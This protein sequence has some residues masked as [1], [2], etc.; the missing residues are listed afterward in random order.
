MD[1][2]GAAEVIS[3]RKILR[4]CVLLVATLGYLHGWAQT[5]PT[6]AAKQLFEQERWSDLAQLL[7]QS[8][9]NNADLDYYYGVALAHLERWAEAGKALSDGQR[10]APNDKRF[11][12]E[13]AGVAF[14]QKKYGEAR[15][16]LHRALRLDAKDEY[17]NEFLATV[18]FLEGNLEAALKYWNR[19][20]KPQVTEVRSEPA[21]KVRPALL[22]HAFAFAPAST[23]TLEELLASN[24]RLRGLEIFST[25]KL[26]LEARPDGKFDAILRAQELNGFGNSKLQALVRIFSGALFEEI[27]PEYYNLHGS[28]TNIISLARFDTDKRRAVAAINGPLGGSP[29]WRYR[30]GADF[31]NENWT[32]QTSFTGSS[33]FLGAT[34]LRRESV[35][36]E[37]TRF[38]G[39]RWSWTTGV[40][41]SHRDFRNV[42]PGVALT[43]ELLAKGYQIKQKAQF[44][45]ELWRSPEKRLTIFSSG[46]SQAGRLWSEP[47]QSFE[48][49]Q[50]AVGM[51]WYPRE[52]GDDYEMQW[53]AHAGKTFGQIPFD[54]LFLLGV[55]RDND[56]PLRA[57]IGTRHGEK[58]SA[59][60]GRNYFLSNWESDR[61]VYSNGILTVKLGPFLDTGK[62]LDSS[63]ALGPHKWLFDLGPQAKL[64]VLGV[65]VVL[66]YGKDLRTGNNAFY[67][68]V[69]W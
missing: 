48:K 68:D 49:L 57:H 39:A 22:D 40:E 7:Q 55:D 15:H 51:H 21:L 16:D 41:F 35:G 53:R 50:G 64:N 52:Q 11:P 34:N 17:A 8:P 66:L 37:I 38:V 6:P 9:R 26:S 59:P 10:L 67:T 18:Y 23:L 27:T 60:L 31:R 43:P 47:G 62:I 69:T 33:T 29:K 61:H 28:G 32:V 63:A 42:V 30:L 12:I 4:V 14:K 54:E 36:A 5:N 65:G 46:K 45:Y 2:A 1:A 19:I 13:L 44:T 25:Y 20:G 56:L 58:G 3:S 24:F